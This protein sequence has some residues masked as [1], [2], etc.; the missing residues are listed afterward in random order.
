MR[1][2]QGLSRLASLPEAPAALACIM[3][4]D[5]PS[6]VTIGSHPPLLMSL[7]RSGRPAAL[8]V[9]A[10]LVVACADGRASADTIDE[11]AGA[12]GALAVA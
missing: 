4:G 7:H 11:S 6:P 8:V 10:S 3:H 2:A 5:D 12:S 9:I 1:G